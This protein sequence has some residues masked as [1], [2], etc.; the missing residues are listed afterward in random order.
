MPKR[1]ARRIIEHWRDGECIGRIELTDKMI[2]RSK[3]GTAGRV[4]AGE[5]RLGNRRRVAIRR[6]WTD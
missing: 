1:V 3:D 4:S 2:Q 5:H 6:G